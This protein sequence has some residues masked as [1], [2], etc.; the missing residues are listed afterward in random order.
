[1]IPYMMWSLLLKDGLKSFSGSVGTPSAGSRESECIPT[2]VACSREMRWSIAGVKSGSLSRSFP[3]PQTG[4]FTSRW[5]STM[6]L[7]T[8]WTVASRVQLRMWYVSVPYLKTRVRELVPG[9]VVKAR[10][11]DGFMI[12]ISTIISTAIYHKP[13]HPDRPP[14]PQRPDPLAYRRVTF[15]SANG[16]VETREFN[17]LTIVYEV[18]M[19][20]TS[21]R[22]SCSFF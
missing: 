3:P 9:N 11:G 21:W 13:T 5:L 2:W 22:S 7:Y 4:D 15:L 10:Y 16:T 14:W 12:V 20:S 17:E 6:E 1:M 8:S 18:P 19:L